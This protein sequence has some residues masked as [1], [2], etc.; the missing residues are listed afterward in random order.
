MATDWIRREQPAWVHGIKRKTAE[1]YVDF[2]H[3]HVLAIIRSRSIEIPHAASLTDTEK[4]LG[5]PPSMY[6]Y[7]GRADDLYG[8]VVFLC[9]ANT[10]NSDPQQEGMCPFDSGGM[11]SGRIH[12]NPL[13][14]PMSKERHEVFWRFNTSLLDWDKLF[15]SHIQSYYSVPSHYV[16]GHP[17]NS[18]PTDFAVV[19]S[20]PPNHS[21]AWTWEVHV[22]CERADT[23]VRARH[24]YMTKARKDE[25]MNW[26]EEQSWEIL[27]EV[28]PW[29][30]SH[31]DTPP[32]GGS[33]AASPVDLVNKFLER[34]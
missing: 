23:R 8:E 12:T 3:R 17:P 30:E 14:E 28:L 24:G 9:H 1:Q 19:C 16:L 18:M 15:L 21:V 13:Y 32:L 31:I 11:W 10:T 34:L 2:F 33:P 20:Q 6:W 22:A 29:I 27:I 7:I 4:S 5:I 26:I 25:V